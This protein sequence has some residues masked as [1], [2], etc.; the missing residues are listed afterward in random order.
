M[1]VVDIETSGLD[2]IKCGLWQI[3]AVDLDSKRV[4][5][6]ESRIDDEDFVEES[7]LKVIGKSEEDLRSPY[8]ESQKQLLDNFFNWCSSCNDKICICQHPQFDISYLMIKARKYGIEFPLSFRAFDLHSFASLKHFQLKGL[9]LKS[10]GFSDMKLSNILSFVG[11]RDNRDAHN[12]LEDAKLTSECF[13]R[14]V[15]GKLFFD[16]YSPYSIPDYLK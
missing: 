16:E 13:Y 11:M 5:F 1:I 14:I 3:G 15:Y 10:E 7:A 8:K 2:P 12:A 9:F 4:F 6:E